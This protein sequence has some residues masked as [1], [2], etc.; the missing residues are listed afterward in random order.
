MTPMKQM[1]CIAAVAAVP[2]SASAAFAAASLPGADN[3]GFSDIA[4]IQGKRGDLLVAQE[5]PP[6]PPGPP[7]FHMG[8]EGGMPPM[9]PEFGPPGGLHGGMNGP[10]CELLAGKLSAMETEIGIRSEQLDAWRDFT[11]ALLAVTAP[12]VR[13]EP[14]APPAAGQPPSPPPKPEAFAQ[15]A[16]MAK[17]TVERGH[18]AEALIKAIDA[19]RTK[20]TPEQIEK[21]KAIDAHFLPPPGGPR[22][23]FG[24][25]PGG[26]GPHPKRGPG[27]DQL[28]FPPFPPR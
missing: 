25:G 28:G 21:V 10:G 20:L 27:S 18:K 5:M 6:A 3:P 12:P 7:P 19:L 2:M 14:P 22:P 11:D 8:L 13:P 17:D 1:L 16:Q 23:P 26:P 4:K 15:A 9:P 24:Q